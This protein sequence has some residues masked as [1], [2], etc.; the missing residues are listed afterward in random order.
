M[1]RPADFIYVKDAV[2]A[3]MLVLGCQHCAGE[4]INIETGKP[5]T[6]NELAK[7][8]MSMFKETGA[9]LEYAAL[10]A[11]GIRNSHGD[12][13]KAGRVLGY[14]P[15]ISLEEGTKRLLQSSNMKAEP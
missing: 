3:S 5:T 7:V 2:E 15:S 12:V 11:G 4:V 1:V 8:L 6:I 9:K 14:K 13:S 10:R